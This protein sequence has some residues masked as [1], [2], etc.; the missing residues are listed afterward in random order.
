[1]DLRYLYLPDTSPYEVF[2]R[3]SAFMRPGARVLDIGCG[4]GAC[5]ILFQ[6]SCKVK[7]LCIEPN[8]ERAHYARTRGLEVMTGYYSP[9][10]IKGHGLCDFVLLTDVLEHIEDP[11]SMLLAIRESLAPGGRVIVSV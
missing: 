9:E 1:E 6:N 2:G 11:G 10:L 8:E 3:V 5:S 7:V 4:T